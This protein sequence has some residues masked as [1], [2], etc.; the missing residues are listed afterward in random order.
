MFKTICMNQSGQY[1]SHL[2]PFFDKIFSADM[3]HDACSQ[4]VTH[5]IDH[6]PESIPEQKSQKSVFFW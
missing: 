4:S 1:C 6:G 2:L 3:S 5:H